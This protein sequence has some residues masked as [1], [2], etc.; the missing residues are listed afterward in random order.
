MDVDEYIRVEMGKQHIPGLALAVARNGQVEKAAGY[1]VANIKSNQ[2]VRPETVFQIQS[3]TKTFTATAMMMLAEEGKITLDDKITQYLSG[4][5]QSWSDITVYHLLTH[6][7]GLKDHCG[8]DGPSVDIEKDIQPEEVIAWVQK[9]P[10]WF[11]PGSKHQYCNFGYYLLGMIIRQ[12]AGKD[13][14]ELVRERILEPLEMHNT[15]VISQSGGNA[16]VAS[17]YTWAN[18]RQENGRYVAPTILAGPG[19]GLNSTV[20]DLAKWDAALY[21]DKILKQSTLAQMWTPAKLKEGSSPEYGIGW[22]LGDY[23]EHRTVY[24]TGSFVTGFQGALVRLVDDK[25]T[26]IV[27]INTTIYKGKNAGQGVLD[28]AQGV[29]EFYT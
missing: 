11:P 16:D 27:F 4:L 13:W 1:G 7:S 24:H 17:G 25:L 22:R 21:T 28:I 12:A 6:T 5:P 3:I 9:F 8:S 10:L 2:P 20:L 23:R 29:A 14:S 19:G 15:R 26:V 18:N